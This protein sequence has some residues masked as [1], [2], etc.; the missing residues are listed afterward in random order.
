MNARTI[1][2][3]FLR[4]YFAGAVFNTRG[5]QNIGLVFVLDPALRS[6]YTGK[7]LQKA[8]KRYLSLLNTHPFWTPMLVGIFLFLEQKIA[9]DVFPLRKQTDLRSTLA[10]TLSGLGDSFLSGSLFIFISLV[11][12]FFL[13]LSWYWGLF[14]FLG[15]AFVLLQI[16]KFYTFYLGFTRGLECLQFLK[17]CDLINLGQRIKIFN[18]CLL[19]LLWFVFLSP[20]C[21]PELLLFGGVC[22]IVAAWLIFSYHG[23]REI[24]FSVLVIVLM[25]WKLLSTYLGIAG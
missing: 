12:I 18:A 7:D 14:L 19:P 2:S 6:L 1:F 24:V 8:R 9:A 3:V 17:R 10:F 4:T 15:T 21:E 22:F 11:S 16:F 13:L 20:R 25:F 23:L 5:L